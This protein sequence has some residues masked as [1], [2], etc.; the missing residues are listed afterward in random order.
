MPDPVLTET[1]HCF[2]PPQRGFGLGAGIIDWLSEFWRQ[3]LGRKPCRQVSR[4][5]AAAAT[6]ILIGLVDSHRRLAPA[7]QPP[8]GGRFLAGTVTSARWFS[9]KPALSTV[10]SMD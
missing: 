6:M 10:I 1:Y 9:D 7:P 5:P 4:P 8:S 3:D 2:G